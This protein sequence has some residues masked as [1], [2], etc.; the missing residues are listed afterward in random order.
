MRIKRVKSISCKKVV[1]KRL[2][3]ASVGFSP[4]TVLVL[5]LLASAVA[6]AAA[7]AAASGEKHL[8]VA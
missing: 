1:R 6:A 7:T 8:S 5:V 4:V 3:Q 2:T